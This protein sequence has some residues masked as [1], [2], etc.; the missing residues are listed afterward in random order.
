MTARD[1]DEVGRTATPLELLFDLSFVIAF[2]VA[3]EE[4]AHLLAV[5]HIKAGIVGFSFAMFAVVWPG[6]STPGSRRSST[7]TI[8]CTGS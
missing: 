1:P 5:G 7:T 6:S 2:G 8:G 4:L 3:G